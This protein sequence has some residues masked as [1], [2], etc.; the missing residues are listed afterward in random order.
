[1][2]S[3]NQI[4]INNHY[5]HYLILTRAI[6]RTEGQINWLAEELQKLNN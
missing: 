5:S 2:K 6:S 4:K 1:M 3:V